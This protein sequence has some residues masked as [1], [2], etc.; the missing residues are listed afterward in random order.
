M[1]IPQAG[2][3]GAG[4]NRMN[5]RDSRRIGRISQTTLSQS[6]RTLRVRYALSVG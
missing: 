3:R 1:G 6:W 4:K 5:F 2:A